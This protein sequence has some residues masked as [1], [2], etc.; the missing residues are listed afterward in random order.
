MS[1]DDDHERGLMG[2][3][4]QAHLV[5]R[6]VV[7]DRSG[8]HR[9]W[10]I[11]RIG[12]LV[13]LALAVVALA[14]LWIW[15]KPIAENVIENELER[16]GVQAT[17]TLDRI[18][19]HNQ[20]IRNL[21]IGD[22]KD[23]D[24]VA[25]RALI[26][27]RVKWNGSVEVYRIVARG[28]RLE[29]TLLESGQVSWGQID[30]LLPPPS[31]RPFR[32]PDIVLDLAD[33]RIGLDTPYGRFGFA[34]AGRGN[35][36]GGFKGR[37]ALA[38]RQLDVG[39]CGL[40]A[41]RG[42]VA[43][44]VVA[45]R[46]QVR[47]PIAAD[48]L[49]C[50]TS[51]MAMVSPRLELDS[52][53]S[54]AF[55]SFRGKGRLAVASFSAGDNGLANLIANI[56]FDGTARDVRGRFDLAAQRARL[57]SIF[58]D[59][60]RLDGRYRLE[61]GKGRLAVVADY[62]ANSANLAAPMIAQLSGPLDA[63]GGTPLGPVARAIA[64]AV[65]R[66]AG[67]FDATGRLVLVNFPGG[68]GVRVETADARGPGG[69]RVQ[70][71]GRDGINY[72]WPSGRMRLD[73]DI[74]MGGG[75]LPRA[76]VS[77]S[78]PRS[79]APMSGEARIAPYAVGGARVALAPVIFRAARDGSTE[80]STTALLS[81]PFSG[82]RVENLRIPISGR[83]GGPAGGFAFGRG[84]IE[85]RFQSL[86]AGA[87][88]LGPTRLPICPTGPAI[89][90]QR[91]DGTLGVG[92]E[93]R[94]LRL[95][96]RLGQS[97][98]LL[99][100]RTAR[101]TGSDRFV[102]TRM[103][104]QLG[105][106]TSPVK[107]EAATLTGHFA[108]G[109]VAGGFD[110]ANATIGQV[111]LKMSEGSGRW[112]YA[113][114]ALDIRG[115]LLVSHLADPPN[116]Y[117]LRG[118]DVRFRLGDDRVHATATLLH[119]D[120]GTKVSDVTIDHR[121]STGD[122]EAIL[123][124]PGIRFGA[125]LQPEELTRLTQGV[126]ALVN[127]G[128]SGQGRIAWSGGGTVT[129]TGDFTIAGMDLAAPFGPVTGMNG[130]IRFTDL[131]GL[132][133]APGQSLTVATINPG[134]LVKDG[135]VR[136]QLLPDR[137]V[138]I[139]R[140]EWPFMGGR[141]ILHETILNF[142]RPTDKRLTFEVVG[143]DAHTFV[144]SMGFK[145][146]DATGTFDGFLPMIF[147]EYGGRIVG[148]RLDARPGGGSLAYNGVVNKANLGTMGNI[149]FEA[150]RDLRFKSMVVRLDGDLAGEFAS[151]LTLDGVALGQTGTQRFI[152]HL[153]RRLPL[154]LNV[155]II[156]PF[157]ALIATAKAFR[158]PRQIIEEVLPRPL[159]EVPG[160]VTEVRRKDE[161]QTQTQAPV[162]ETIEA[163]PPA[164]NPSER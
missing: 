98:F 153:L 87:L 123:D 69:A 133:T 113:N 96:G 137:L 158:D 54:E 61:A 75:G 46:P 154:K 148:G 23:P 47:G 32:L 10:R 50:P 152:R 107:V 91:A 7:H 129:S 44:A 49:N 78:Q 146:L 67:N 127:G 124:V 55:A 161:E 63:A 162:E 108:G 110:G 59:R 38:S 105:K 43:I 6:V 45:R 138:K 118:N 37:L 141:L 8:W 31:G 145:E 125:N 122:G 131:L 126:I 35:L 57:A 120:S 29:G 65:R 140:G 76:E 53:F 19:L 142:A 33:S 73:T 101:L 134:I 48:A 89:L 114:A 17:Y 95:A 151:R 97:P 18:G 150:L 21:V 130:T 143:L 136:Y 71:A 52:N 74:S 41:L 26:Q 70:V 20:R 109:G 24:L 80:V 121:V 51:R 14:I 66:T 83:I 103:A 147:N 84:C 62:G 3:A 12:L 36:K 99:N 135:V 119:P 13:L 104:M 81:G 82:G 1:V 28:V 156:G 27:M 88:R 56:G 11:S 112:T 68:G 117:P 93:A 77:L 164:T 30:K 94:D 42:N 15:R 160:I 159:D 22:P 157:R 144:A 40:D 86:R 79:G 106:S 116:F 111:P 34:L 85:A 2:E 25:R 155:T 5:E 58:A 4:E 102:L 60:T 139:E 92:A 90:Y 149:A 100:A 39:A 132:E 115:S 128:L 163:N 16:R 9:A 72:Y 64:A